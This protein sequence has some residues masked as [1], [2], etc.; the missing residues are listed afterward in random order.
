MVGRKEHG[1]FLTQEN[2]T[3]GAVC[4]DGL[5]GVI[6][7]GNEGKSNIFLKLSQK[8][9]EVRRNSSMGIPVPGTSVFKREILNF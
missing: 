6:K 8:Q 3:S 2:I 9:E 5:F 7:K 4:R 1:F